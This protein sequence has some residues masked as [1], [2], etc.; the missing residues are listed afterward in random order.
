MKGRRFSGISGLSL[1]FGRTEGDVE[2]RLLGASTEPRSLE[3]PFVDS[4][5][6]AARDLLSASC[7]IVFSSMTPDLADFK[8]LRPAAV[9]P[10]TVE[11]E[12]EMKRVAAVGAW[13]RP[14]FTDCEFGRNCSLPVY[15]FVDSE[16]ST[17]REKFDSPS[18]SV[19]KFS[20]I[21]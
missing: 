19:P 4:T 18:T 20:S 12:P 15:C 14:P 7:L 3:R 2:T 16:L 11:P 13:L 1:F 10:A 17:G 6:P 5:L 21:L 9:M 8:W